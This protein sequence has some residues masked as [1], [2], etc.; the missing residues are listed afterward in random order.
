MIV[1]TSNKYKPHFGGIENSLYFLSRE[2]IALGH[3]VAILVD[4]RS[5][6]KNKRLSNKDFEDKVMIIR[7]KS[8]FPKFFLDHLI[9]PIIDI[10]RAKIEFKKL[11]SKHNIEKI[12]GRNPVPILAALSLGLQVNYLVP[13]IAKTQLKVSIKN[14]LDFKNIYIKNLVIPFTSY[15]QKKALQKSTNVLAF[16]FNMKNQIQDF[17]G[18][19]VAVKL[20]NAGVDSSKFNLETPDIDKQSFLGVPNNHFVFLTVGR[21]VKDKGI[22]YAVESFSKIKN[23]NSS[24]IIVG[25]GIERVSLENQIDKLG[26]K[27]RVKLVGKV[28]ENI[29]TYYK[30]SDCFVMCSIMEPFGQ[31]ILEGLATGLPVIAWKSSKEI[32]T[33]TSEIID[34]RNGFIID[35]DIKK[36]SE[37]M[38]ELTEMDSRE[39]NILKSNNVKLINEKY[40]WKNLALK[41]LDI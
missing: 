27:S 30:L 7:Y 13:G 19:S 3:E 23:T 21:L 39:Y 18:K 25:E 26:L 9:K 2:Y 17:A 31:T 32:Q 28:L 6:E 33:A 22:K 20:V 12:L 5:L 11:K 40:S 34:E 4:D 10:H 37:C 8:Y 41:N 36:M 24:L 15:L 29:E 14:F 38:Q 35:F 1:L 16:S